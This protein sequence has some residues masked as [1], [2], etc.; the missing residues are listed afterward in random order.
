MRIIFLALI[1]FSCNNH[2]NL[3]KQKAY[4]AP[5]FEIPTY[6][7]ISLDCNY[8]FN[9]HETHVYMK[10]LKFVTRMNIINQNITKEC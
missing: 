10:Y 3:P 8:S 2:V 6:K 9:I 7:K 5:E 4:F 1:V